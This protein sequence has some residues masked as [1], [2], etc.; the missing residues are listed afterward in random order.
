M[1][2][3]CMSMFAAVALSACGGSSNIGATGGGAGA[4]GN[5]QLGTPDAFA[6]EVLNIVGT[7]NETADPV[8]IEGIALTTPEDT[9]P[10]AL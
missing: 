7:T 10:V 9:Y 3:L 6:A 1:K 4:G 5:A 8:A 2:K